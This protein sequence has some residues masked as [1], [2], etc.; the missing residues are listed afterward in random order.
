MPAQTLAPGQPAARPADDG[1]S[2]LLLT[3]GYAVLTLVL[4]LGVVDVTALYLARRDL[5][6]VAD[7]AALTA[8]QQ[9]S[10]GAAYG[11]GRLDLD[12]RAV[13]AVYAQYRSRYVAAG[14]PRDIDWSSAYAGA[15]VDGDAVDVTLRR[16]VTV[17]FTAAFTTVG[18]PAVTVT[19]TAHA[20]ARLLCADC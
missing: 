18:L 20:R 2:V 12:Q 14:G 15:R 7:G 8:A 4:V 16:A 10:V 9:L 6:T 13:A 17:P 19:V 5:Q 1:G 11:E 3:L